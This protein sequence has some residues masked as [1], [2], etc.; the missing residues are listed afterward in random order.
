[1]FEF[2]Y[3]LVNYVKLSFKFIFI[4]NVKNTFFL[5]IKYLKKLNYT[6]LLIKDTVFYT[7]IKQ[8]KKNLY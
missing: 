5:F 4:K 2:M 8:K 1:M 3:K 7:K 6:N